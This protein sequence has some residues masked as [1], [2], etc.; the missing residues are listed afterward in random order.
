MHVFNS[1]FESAFTFVRSLFSLP[2]THSRDSSV[3]TVTRLRAGRPG[4]DSRHGQGILLLVTAPIS[5]LRP[6]YSPIQ[7]ARRLFSRG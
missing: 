4:L 2:C 1:I 7:W 3:S 6:T 5:A